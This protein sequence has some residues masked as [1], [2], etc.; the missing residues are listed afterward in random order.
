MSIRSR[1]ARFVA[2]LA[3]AAIAPSITDAQAAP[4]TALTSDDLDCWRLPRGTVS[5]RY[6][7]TVVLS[8]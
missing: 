4:A 5:F 6:R 7:L 2:V 8:V 3:V 1:A